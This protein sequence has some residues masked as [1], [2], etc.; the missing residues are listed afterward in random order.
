ML[1]R[2]GEGEE[3]AKHYERA[4]SDDRHHERHRIAIDRDDD[5][6]SLCLSILL[7]GH[8]EGIRQPPLGRRGEEGGDGSA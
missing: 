2:E 8:F 3:R 4:G 1:G 7:R 5:H 6:A